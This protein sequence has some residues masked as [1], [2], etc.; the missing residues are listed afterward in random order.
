[1]RVN[2]KFCYLLSCML[3][4][5]TFILYEIILTYTRS[6]ARAYADYIVERAVVHFCENVYVFSYANC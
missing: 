6:G 5:A 1:M 2:L 3:K 4:L